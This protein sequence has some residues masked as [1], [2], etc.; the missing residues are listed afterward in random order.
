MAS[1]WLSTALSEML[2]EQ[3]ATGGALRL[4]PG[5]TVARMQRELPLENASALSNEELVRIGKILNSDFVVH[6][7]YQVVRA[8][9]DRQLRIELLLR[10]TRRDGTVEV[11]EHTG[12]EAQLF[13]LVS[14]VTTELRG[15]LRV[16]NLSF[17][18]LRSLKA[19]RPSSTE[20]FRLYLDGLEKLRS[21]NALAARESLEQAVAIDPSYA[22][23]QAVLSQALSA[24]G[25]D[26][27]AE[28]SGRRADQL[29]EG[30]PREDSLQIQGRYFEVAGEWA[31]AIQTYEALLRLFPDSVDY[32]LRLAEAQVMAGRGKD[33]L[34]TVAALREP[35]ALGAGDPRMDLAEARAANSLADYRLQ[36]AAARRA[37]QKGVTL[38]AS[39]LI[40]DARQSQ[41]EAHF[42]LV[43]TDEATAAFEEA[44]DLF[45]AAGDLGK[46][47]QVLSRIADV[48]S[49]QEDT[50]GAFELHQEA[51]VI[52]RQTGNRRGVSQVQN[53]MAF[54]LYQQGD[55]AAARAMLEEAV[56]IAREIG[57]RNSEANYLDTLIEVLLREGKIE[58]ADELAQEERAIYKELGNREGLAWSN[59]YLGRIALAAGDVPGARSRYDEALV[60]SDEIDHSYFTSFVLDDLAKGLLAAGDVV[61]ALRMSADSRRFRSDLG[62]YLLAQSQITAASIL[63]EKGRAADAEDLAREA[64]EVFQDNA[65]LD[66]VATAA[67]VL[68]QTFLV[69][70]ESAEAESAL[71]VGRAHARNS[72]NPTVR[73]LVA[74]T[75]A[76]LAAGTGRAA[77]AIEVL[78][79]VA[80]EAHQR[81]LIKLE[82]EARLAWGEIEIAADMR[83]TGVEAGRQRLEALAKK[84]RELGCGLI[85]RKAGVA[86]AA[87]GSREAPTPS[88]RITDRSSPSG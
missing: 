8:G 46:V 70:G 80:A 42:W 14:E 56:A 16:K 73:L 50:A 55:L 83:P 77:E 5:E 67:A 68:A 51:L 76:E 23:A 24:L 87:T 10:E 85:L 79:T 71:A 86:L 4:V 52:H 49:F 53:S 40:A 75:G 82:L 27:E 38:G 18:E 72:Q 34:A 20:A 45:A 26:R 74:M 25:Y 81:G 62:G 60:I 32:G 36:L 33:A 19:K 63:L 11:I 22:L 69:R 57:D 84:A 35:P 13:E 28:E 2:T 65:R 7:A 64:I 31:R 1:A 15:A 12:T 9:G 61:G 6:G 47:A 44:R 48:L 29:A 3:L 41:G 39:I 78:E 66:D 58:A 17:S 43:E 59:Y 30:L 88:I 54:Q 37:A 21:F